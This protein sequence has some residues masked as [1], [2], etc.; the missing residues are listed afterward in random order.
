[1]IVQIGCFFFVSFVYLCF[2]FFTPGV[3]RNLAQATGLGCHGYLT[4]RCLG[5]AGL[6]RATSTGKLVEHDGND[7]EGCGEKKGLMDL[8]GMET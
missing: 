6:V 2:P 7:L 3:L 4:S 5:G 8:V 1:M